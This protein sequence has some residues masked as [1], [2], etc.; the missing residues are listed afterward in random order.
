MDVEKLNRSFFQV[1]STAFNNDDFDLFVNSLEQ[2]YRNSTKKTFPDV[3]RVRRGDGTKIKGKLDF[4]A[5]DLED[6]FYET[7]SSGV[8]YVD[9]DDDGFN[10]NDED[11]DDEECSTT[12]S[13][14][15]HSVASLLSQ[16]VDEI[17]IVRKSQENEPKIEEPPKN[18]ALQKVSQ[19]FERLIHTSSLKNIFSYF[20]EDVKFDMGSWASLNKIPSTPKLNRDP[21][22]SYDDENYDNKVYLYKKQQKSVDKMIEE[23]ERSKRDYIT[24]QLNLEHTDEEFSSRTSTVGRLDKN[25]IQF[26][27]NICNSGD[28]TSVIQNKLNTTFIASKKNDDLEDLSFNSVKSMVPL[29]KALPLGKFK[30]MDISDGNKIFDEEIPY[31]RVQV[32]NV[33]LKKTNDIDKNVMKDGFMKKQAPLPPKMVDEEPFSLEKSCH[34]NQENKVIGKKIEKETVQ[35]SERLLNPSPIEFDKNPSPS[36]FNNHEI[37]TPKRKI[38][39]ENFQQSDSLWNPSPVKFEKNSSPIKLEKNSSQVHQNASLNSQINLSESTSNKNSH[40]EKQKYENT[41]PNKFEVTKQRQPTLMTKNIDDHKN[42]SI[43]N[44]QRKDDIL[45]PSPREFV[46]S[47]LVDQNFS[48]ISE[49]K[50][51]NR[52]ISRS[53]QKDMFLNPSPIEKAKNSSPMKQNRS[54][55]PHSYHMKKSILKNNVQKI[56]DFINSSPDKTEVNSSPMDQNWEFMA[57]SD[58]IIARF[59]SKP[60]PL[61]SE[62]FVNSISPK[63]SMNPS[64]AKLNEKIQDLKIESPKESTLNLT[65]KKF[66]HSSLEHSSPITPVKPPIIWDTYPGVVKVESFTQTTPKRM[67]DG[68]TNTSPPE[69]YLLDWT[70]GMQSISFNCLAEGRESLST[71]CDTDLLNF[72]NFEENLFLNVN[73]KSLLLTVENLLA[74][75]DLSLMDMLCALV[76]ENPLINEK[77]KIILKTKP[78]PIEAITEELQYFIFS[79]LTYESNQLG[80]AMKITLTDPKKGQETVLRVI[81]H[82]IDKEELHLVEEKLC[83]SS[84]DVLIYVSFIIKVTNRLGF[85]VSYVLIFKLL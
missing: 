62:L 1:E 70:S 30:I 12:S 77:T 21:F 23:F 49:S 28:T 63:K 56:K 9:I 17:E 73:D 81:F 59:I 41:S 78:T 67:S 24:S 16:S 72:G 38:K 7:L 39:R 5:D 64:P 83:D 13:R 51:L 57:E 6:D 48:F 54:A 19:S 35:K 42:I 52:S 46:N 8:S 3:K 29:F 79:S 22:L 82:A 25:R 27:E 71:L 45:N 26:F 40:F 32:H 84:N 58:D 14:T 69:K 44:S 80:A 34:S 68:G 65:P 47:S 2:S 55:I 43:E 10:E 18:K 53:N 75:W 11:A 76:T 15:R 74:V 4:D 36:H 33:N 20:D 37:K 85:H 60:G 66:H 61:M 31:Q 50:D